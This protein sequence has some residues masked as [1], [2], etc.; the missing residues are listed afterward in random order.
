MKENKTIDFSNF[1]SVEITGE[2]DTRIIKVNCDGLLYTF[3]TVHS[4]DGKYCSGSG[5]FVNHKESD[6]VIDITTELRLNINCDILHRMTGD[7]I[8]INWILFWVEFFLIGNNHN[9]LESIL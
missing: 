9:H 7:T 2:G 1:Q 3:N 6:A 4:K 8:T 5:V